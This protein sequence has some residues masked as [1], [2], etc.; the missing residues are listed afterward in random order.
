MPIF[1]CGVCAA[2]WFPRMGRLRLKTPEWFGL[3]QE[4]L[5]LRLRRD[6]GDGAETR[7]ADG[8]RGVGEAQ[9]RFKGPA[10]KIR[11]DERAAKD[12]AGAGGVDGVDREGGHPQQAIAVERD[13]A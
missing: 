5:R 10:F 11:I 4:P 12:I 2:L 7:A 9:R 1:L 8:G 6:A 13:G 3:S